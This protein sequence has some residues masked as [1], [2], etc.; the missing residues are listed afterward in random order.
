MDEWPS[1]VAAGGPRV[2]AGGAREGDSRVPS[3]DA[4]SMTEPTT[5]PPIPKAEAIER[6][7]GARDAIDAL[8]PRILEGEPWPLA[9]D[10]GV[11]PEA[12]W[13]PRE[14]L[15]HTAEMLPFWQGEME[16]VIEAARPVG[17]ALPYGRVAADAMRLGI[18][19]RDRT[20]PLRELFDR[21]DTGIAR[22]EART[23][24]LTPEEESASGVHVRDGELPATWIRDRFVIRHLEEHVSQLEEILAR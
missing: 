24:T 16:R 18:L 22:W 13:G 15:A 4:G 1:T 7:R 17:D 10:F 19:D 14:V 21:I 5:M 2:K 9:D 8:R 12:S 23:A 11:G 20:L 6:L 3:G